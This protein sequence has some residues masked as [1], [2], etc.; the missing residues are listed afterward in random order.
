MIK[1]IVITE[2]LRLEARIALEL[3]QHF[4]IIAGHP[5]GVDDSGRQKMR[6]LTPDE[7]VERACEIAHSATTEFMSRGWLERDVTDAPPDGVE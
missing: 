4:G 2:T 1:K 5:D 7:V 6:M 3:M